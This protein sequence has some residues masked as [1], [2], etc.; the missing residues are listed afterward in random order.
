VN[1]EDRAPNPQEPEAPP[2]D[3]GEA[4]PWDDSPGN[5]QE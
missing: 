4:P 2:T 5:L 3:G 1:P